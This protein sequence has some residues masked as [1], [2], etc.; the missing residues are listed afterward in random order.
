MGPDM[1]QYNE[2]D[3][4]THD[5]LSFKTHEPERTETFKKIANW[6]EEGF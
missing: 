6:L 4:A 3:W 5:Y 2:V 1:V